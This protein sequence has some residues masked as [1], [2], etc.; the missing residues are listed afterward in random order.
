M[1]EKCAGLFLELCALDNSMSPPA[2]T[3]DRP[4]W[5]RVCAALGNAFDNGG[6][7]YLR[8]IG[9]ESS[10]VKEL[11]MKSLLGQYRLIVLTNSSDPKAELQ[12]WWEPGDSPFRGTVRFGDD[13]WDARTVCSDLSVAQAM[14]REFFNCGDL[15]TGLLHIR[16][17]WNPK[18]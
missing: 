17:Q 6:F 12:E 4:V 15:R 5:E 9:S 1:S 8:V 10:F 16:S 14:F 18:P 3:T 7:V 2:E 13:D 11:C